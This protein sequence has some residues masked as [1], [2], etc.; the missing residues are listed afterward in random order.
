MDGITSGQ[1]Q[2]KKL[3]NHILKKLNLLWKN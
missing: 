3:G 1:S 2:G